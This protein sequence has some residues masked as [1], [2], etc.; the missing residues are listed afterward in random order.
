[1]QLFLL[2]HG[3]TVCEKVDPA[4]PLSVAGRDEVQRMAAFLKQAEFTV[5]NFF[6]SN[7]DRACQSADIV[8]QV[9]NPRAVLTEKS[10]LAPS[11]DIAEI[12]A[13]IA[14]LRENTLIA[15]HLPFL[16]SL[17]S[18]LVVADEMKSIVNFPTGGLVILELLSPGRWLIAGV[19][20]PG[21]LRFMQG[22]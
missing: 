5:E 6:H 1:M 7:K 4:R 14:K 11:D 13:E 9:V 22:E 12:V 2:R 17:V 15:G 20:T 18:Y 21:V 8:R 3:E 10:C 19:Y 16:S